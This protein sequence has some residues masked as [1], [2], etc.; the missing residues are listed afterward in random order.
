M[1]RGAK[2]WT[3]IQGHLRGMEGRKV[4]EN[5]VLKIAGSNYPSI[6]TSE[7]SK[8]SRT[9]EQ[10]APSVANACKT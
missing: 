6:I 3:K 7:E 9:L 4:N 2:T 8:I 10:C 1:Y 5:H